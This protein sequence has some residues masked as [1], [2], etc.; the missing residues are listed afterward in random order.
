LELRF[1]G[2]KL[3][4]DN[5]LF[6]A[7]A[8]YVEADSYITMVGE[9]EDGDEFWRWVFD[10]QHVYRVRGQAV[11]E[12]SSALNQLDLEHLPGFVVF[13]WNEER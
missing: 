1:T 8:P 4:D 7:L 2:Q 9:S 11:F 6:A 3:G 13:K 10:G 5:I 12:E